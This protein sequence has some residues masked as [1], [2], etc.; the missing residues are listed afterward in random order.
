MDT[1]GE[2]SAL[3][4]IDHGS[5]LDEANRL[6]EALA[7]RIQRR[8]PDIIIAFAHMEL[9]DPDLGSA[10]ASCVDRG[11][12]SVVIVPYFLAPGNHVS[13]DVPRLARDAAKPYPSVPWKV[14]APLG[15]DDRLVEIVLDR[16]AD[17]LKVID[18][19]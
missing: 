19:N 4:L 18:A 14:A 7:D 13:H 6:I 10:F 8:R 1:R 15:L 9:A 3:I 11:A 17:A 2:K 5:R 12:R 16:A